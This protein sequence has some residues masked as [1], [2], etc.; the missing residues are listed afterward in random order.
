[1]KNVPTYGPSF[2]VVFFFSQREKKKSAS[3]LPRVG[4]PYNLSLF[5]S[6][7]SCAKVT[8]KGKKKRNAGL[9]TPQA[10]ASFWQ[11]CLFSAPVRLFMSIRNGDKGGGGNKISFWQAR[12]RYRTLW[13]LPISSLDFFFPLLTI[14]EPSRRALFLFS[15]LSTAFLLGPFLA[16]VRR[17]R[18]VWACPL[19]DI[20]ME[21]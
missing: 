7:L 15:P 13:P 8:K 20:T 3:P 17:A 21:Q 5:V 10:L 11:R 14:W 6:C 19:V 2:L 9:D 18:L 1:M 4:P 16:R 12:T